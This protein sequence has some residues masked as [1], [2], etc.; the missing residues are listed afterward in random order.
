MY[1]RDI[2][3]S[4]KLERVLKEGHFSFTAE[5]G[6]PRGANVEKVKKKDFIFKG[7]RRCCKY[8]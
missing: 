5:L 7:I 2:E 8:N 3:E 1:K 4:S 6:P